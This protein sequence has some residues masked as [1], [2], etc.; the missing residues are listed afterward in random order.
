MNGNGV[1]SYADAQRYRINRPG[2]QEVIRQSLYDTL[3]Y[4]AAGHT[5]L[6]FFQ[7]PKGQSGKTIADTNMEQAGT[8]PN[9]KS[10][11]IESIE[12]YWLS[13][14][15]PVV[16]NNSATVD[17]VAPTFQND[18]WTIYKSG[19]LDLF[20]GSKSYLQEAP[21]GR[22]PPK[23]RL[24]TS[25][26]AAIAIAQAAAADDA[27]QVTGNYA[28]WGGRPYFLKP[29]SVLIPP[30]QNFSV[31]LTWPSAVAL[32]SANDARIQCVLEGYLYRL[33]Q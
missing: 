1:P 8:L 32:A 21:I 16:I 11:L 6:Q 20:I 10:F 30:T 15:D 13:G 26:G 33:S 12:L 27:A 25:F 5:S 14:D 29:A 28:S 31:T 19:S 23:T 7:T 2:E 22:F 24:D 4:D 18:S 3:T 9:P 17:A